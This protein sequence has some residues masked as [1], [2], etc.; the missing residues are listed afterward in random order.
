MSELVAVIAGGLSAERDVSIRS[1]RRI[2]E[3]LRKAG[4][5]VVILDLDSSLIDELIQIK[6]ACVF[7]LV[8]GSEG[9]AGSLQEVLIALGLPFVGTAPN[10]CRRGFDKSVASGLMEDAGF[11]IPDHVVMPQS[12]FRELGAG[13]LLEIVANQIGL[14]IMV[15]PNRGGSALGATK[16][17]NPDELP[18]AMVAAFAY[19]DEVIIEQFIEGTE[20]AVSVVDLGEGP[21]ALPAVEIIPD[22]GIYDFSARYTAGTTEFFVPA[23]LSDD[24]LA[25]AYELAVASHTLLG[26]R[27]WSRT[28]MIVN[29]DGVPHFIQ[30]NVVPGVTETSLFPQS[31]QA[32]NFKFP[33]LLATLVNKA[34]DRS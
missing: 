19:S 7:P 10:G 28:D 17:N 24:T 21:V 16:V 4:F 6:P 31:V 25:K 27:D 3:E 32:S 23:R 2:A 1:G 14:P 15:K 20:I 34:I 5:E 9:E 33:E 18:S 8:H 26:A 29:S 22:S 13:R 12:V 30:I 11:A